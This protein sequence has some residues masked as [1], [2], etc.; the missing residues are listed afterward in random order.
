MMDYISPGKRGFLHPINSFR[1][2]WYRA[3]EI[4]KIRLADNASPFHPSEMLDQASGN[5]FEQLGFFLGIVERF[6]A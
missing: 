3:E 4:S 2:G 6:Y 1:H 5:V